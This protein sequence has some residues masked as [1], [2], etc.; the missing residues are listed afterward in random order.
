LGVSFV[1]RVTAWRS[2]D[3]ANTSVCKWG[4]G[5][6]AAGFER[7]HNF[8]VSLKKILL[9]PDNIDGE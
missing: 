6:K 3:G 2:I 7:S 1:V 5:P 9:L 8:E 4:N